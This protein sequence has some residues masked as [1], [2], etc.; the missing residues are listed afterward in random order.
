MPIIEDLQRKSMYFQVDF[1][2]YYNTENG[3]KCTLNRSIVKAA[4]LD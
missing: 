3:T 2:S 1:K 4:I